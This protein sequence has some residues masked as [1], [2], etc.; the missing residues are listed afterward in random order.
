MKNNQV[1]ISFITEDKE[2]LSVVFEAENNE[3]SVVT[4]FRQQGTHDLRRENYL[5]AA[6]LKDVFL[7]RKQLSASLELEA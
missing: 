2:Q 1:A 4:T 5:K 6:V 7:Q 3:T